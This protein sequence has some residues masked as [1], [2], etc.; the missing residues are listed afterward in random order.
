[1]TD[2]RALTPDDQERWLPLWQGYLTFY[3]ATLPAAVTAMTWQRLIDPAEPVHGALAFDESGRAVG[4]VQWIFHRSTWSEGSVCYL[5]DLFV[6]PTLRGK[7]TGRALIAH[8]HA[9][10]L[11]NG[12][13]KVYWLTHETN[14]TAQ[15]LYNAVAERTGFI[16]YRQLLA[17]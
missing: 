11:A 12:A 8:V 1:M 4:L 16:Q 13:S 14:Q 17:P 6:D 2:I 5:N 15:K 3:E 10:A 9:D 7:G